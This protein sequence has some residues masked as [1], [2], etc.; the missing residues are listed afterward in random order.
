MA[1]GNRVHASSASRAVLLERTGVNRRLGSSV[2]PD[3]QI[4]S[5]R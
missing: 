2:R 4:D 3:R 1:R 5:D